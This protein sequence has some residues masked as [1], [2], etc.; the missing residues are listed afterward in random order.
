VRRHDDQGGSG[1]STLITPEKAEL[2][3]V[4]DIYSVEELR[5]QLR[6]L[7]F[8]DVSLEDAE[9]IRGELL[10]E[11]DRMMRGLRA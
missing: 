4:A 10:A 5:H 7:G 2:I 8:E 3:Y 9:A 1:L 11:V 6:R